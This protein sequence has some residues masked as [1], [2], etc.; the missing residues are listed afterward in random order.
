MTKRVLLFYLTRGSGHHAAAKAVV[1]AMKQVEPEVQ[2]LSLDAF[3]YSN[4]VLSKVVLKTYLGVIRTT[5][6][7]WDYLYDN[8]GVQQKLAK[9]RERFNR[10]TS[11][12]L[13]KI[14]TDFRPDLIV[15]TQA[16]SCN[17]VA[18][19][20][21]DSGARVPLIGVLTD[22][23]AHRYWGNEHTDRYIA[24]TEETAITLM[25]QGVPRE[26]IRAFG[27]P[28]SP[29]FAVEHDKSAL[30]RK[31]G[32]SP[33]VPRLLIMGG[34]RALGPMK[35]IVNKLDK[36]PKPFEMIV[37][38]SFNR[39]L[40]EK[41]EEKREKLRHPMH[42]L[43][44]VNNMSEWMTVADLLITKPGGLTTSEALVKCLP[45]VICNPI[46]GQEI[47]NTKFLLANRVAVRADEP[48]EVAAEVKALLEN[49]AQLAKMRQRAAELRRPNAALD[50]ARDALRL[51]E[52]HQ[53]T[54]AVSS[55]R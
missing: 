32:L 51:I 53:R 28:I 45:M 25:A 4:P 38:T 5:P 30:V 11:E 31:L 2:T 34:S 3:S 16:F 23:V 33:G 21:K 24:P 55:V 39:A 1:E 9:I 54:E 49:P 15:C 8:P 12:K 47:K 46:P 41:L 13:Q 48:K 43:G 36:I 22:F 7:L 14:I 20:K 29:A 52:E 50:T 18:N 6:E 37:I 26:R 42:V 19:Y 27:I 17:V 40:H 44:F 35:S 10:A